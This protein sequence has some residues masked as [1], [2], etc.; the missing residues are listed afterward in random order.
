MNR[1]DFEKP[2]LADFIADDNTYLQDT[3]R[4]TNLVKEF[5]SFDKSSSSKVNKAVDELNLSVY[6]NQILT[7]L[8]HN[9][10]GKTTT[11]SMIT[12]FLEASSGSINA[13]GINAFEQ[14]DH[15]NQVVG[16]CP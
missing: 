5:K 11:I 13:F 7:L 4:I 9:G 6:K 15:M 3:C 10:A 14:R 1:G 16:I 2:N 12:G 8:G